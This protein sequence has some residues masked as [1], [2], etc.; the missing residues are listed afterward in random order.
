MSFSYDRVWADVIAMIRTNAALLATLAGVFVFLPA[1]ALGMYAPM[2]APPGGGDGSEGMRFLVDY[3]R[4][5]LPLLVLVN[6][7]GTFG[8]AAILSLLL[9]QD[10]PTV[11]EALGSCARL[12]PIYFVLTIITNFAVVIGLF[13]FLVP[14]I[15]LLGRLSIAGPVMIAERVGSPIE[16]IRRGWTYTKG[17]GWRI[18]G[19]AML[20]GIVAWIAVSAAS[21]VLAVLAGLLLPTGSRVI[22][23]AFADA[24][25]GAALAVLIAVLVAAIYRQL[26]GG[27][28][29]LQNIFS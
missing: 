3:Y 14:G 29:P 10:R 27:T 18:A 26:R 8:Q 16:A 2:P 23:R 20:V 22:A 13:L 19:L 9:D 7:I 4:A 5:N 6:I 15:Y 1:L 17:L 21:S 28:A 11:G 25:G 12:L 24:L